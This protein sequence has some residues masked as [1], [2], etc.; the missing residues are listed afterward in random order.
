MMVAVWRSRRWISSWDRAQAHA[1]AVRREQGQVRELFQA[2]PV[3]LPEGDPDVDFP[4]LS[5]EIAQLLASQGD[6]KRPGH[7]L[8][9]QS[10]LDGPLPVDGD[11]DLP[12]PVADVGA[13]VH[14]AVDRGQ[15]AHDFGRNA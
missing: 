14:Q 6:R 15:Y 10:H 5:P 2:L 13:H 4:V 9:I 7:A 1:P 3:V 12:V 8:G 11:L